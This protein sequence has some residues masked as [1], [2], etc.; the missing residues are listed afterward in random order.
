MC[1][2]EPLYLQ[3]FALH[4]PRWRAGLAAD[5]LPRT[6][7]LCRVIARP[8][9]GDARASLT[10]SYIE[11]CGCKIA[12][13]P[14]QQRAE[15]VIG[16]RLCDFAPERT[17][18]GRDSYVCRRAGPREERASDARPW[19]STTMRPMTAVAASGRGRLHRV[20]RRVTADSIASEC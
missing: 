1:C 16:S 15:I 20:R 13:R 9:S 5:L 3:R 2:C 19:P 10:S 12:P 17:L 7:D 4:V 8:L 14:P 11:V 18:C 6:D